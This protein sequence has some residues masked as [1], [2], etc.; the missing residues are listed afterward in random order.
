MQET[1]LRNGEIDFIIGATRPDNSDNN[2]ITEE[3]FEDQLAIIVRKGHPLLSKP[4]LSLSD[5]KDYH[6]VLPSKG[7]PSRDLFNTVLSSRGIALPAH[8]IE[9]S[10]LAIIRGLLLESDHISLL[11]DHQIY[12]DK[13]FGLL[14][15][16]PIELKDTY[17]LIG[18][19]MHAQIQPSPAAQLFL[20]SLR[21]VV[22]SLKSISNLE[23]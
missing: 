2:L 13:L 14:R 12:Y 1:L 5:L 22:A 16:L 18:V 20:E 3:L 11:S 10:S 9:T 19:T 4:D 6:W 21:E 7:T 23:R 17:R 15:S 8:T